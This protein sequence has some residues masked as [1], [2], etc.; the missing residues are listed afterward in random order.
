MLIVHLQEP[1]SLSRAL[2]KARTLKHLGGAGP[3]QVRFPR[4]DASNATQSPIAL[5]E[6]RALV[7]QLSLFEAQMW[8][9]WSRVRN[10]SLSQDHRAT[11]PPLQHRSRVLH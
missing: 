9:P 5:L 8:V 3:C 2:T 10:T 4:P 6:A 7:L 1:P 11:Y